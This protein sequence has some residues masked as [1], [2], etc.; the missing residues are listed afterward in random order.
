MKDTL[1]RLI[2][3][4]LVL[5]MVFSMFPAAYAAEN[6][7][8]GDAVT[9][10]S[11]PP[12]AT[13]PTEALASEPTIANEETPPAESGGSSEPTV[14]A[15]DPASTDP[16]AGTT[17][18]DP[19]GDTEA[20][21]P[22]E[23]T[24][25]TE[26]SETT[27]PADPTEDTEPVEPTLESEATEPAEESE[28]TETTEAT[29]PT[30]EPTEATAATQ[31]TD[32][33]ET[34]EP[35]E[36]TE[37]TGPVSDP[38]ADV[39]SAAVWEAT[40]S[41]VTLTGDAVTDLLAIAK[42]QL[43][44]T[45]STRNFVVEGE[46]ED[47]VT[48]GY[49]RYGAWYGLP[50][51][52][53]CAMFV[54][55][56][57]SYAGLTDIPNGAGCQTWINA[58]TE[59]GLYFEADEYLA[60]PGDVIFFDHDGDGRADHVGI[61]SEITED[62]YVTIEGNYSDMVTYVDRTDLDEITGFLQIAGAQ[63]TGNELV[64][65]KI[66]V[67]GGN[68]AISTFASRAV[69]NVSGTRYT[70]A[71]I[72]FN[73][74]S[75]VSFPN[76]YSEQGMYLH[77]VN[78]GDGS[79]HPAYC[80]EPGVN[81]G[82]SYTGGTAQW[83]ALDSSTQKALG[84]TLMY[85]A[86]NSYTSSMSLADKLVY[87][88][89]TQAVIH[90]IMCGYRTLSNLGT[91]TNKSLYNAMISAN[92]PA[93]NMD[94]T[95]DSGYFKS[96]AGT[97]LNKTL[98]AQAYAELE[99][100]I[101]AHNTIP[102][103]TSSDPNDAP[104]YNMT[105]NAAGT[106]YQATIYIGPGLSNGTY[107]FVNGNGLSYEVSGNYLIVSAPKSTTLSGTISC[108]WDGTS[109]VYKNVPSLDEQTFLLWSS[110]KYQELVQ[111]YVNVDAPVPLYFNVRIN[112]TG[113]AT[114]YKTATNGGVEGYAFKFY[115]WKVKDTDGT[116]IRESQTWYAKTGASGLAYPADENYN[117]TDYS[118]GFTFPDA[119]NGTY[120]II[121]V[122]SETPGAVGTAFPDSWT[123]TVYKAD[124]T[125]AN[126]NTY[127]V[128]MNGSYDNDIA[129]CI[130]YE[131][132]GA[133]AR[134]REVPITGLEAGGHVELKVNNYSEPKT[135][136]LSV[137]KAVSQSSLNTSA[138]KANWRIELYDTWAKATVGGTNYL[139]YAYTNSSGNVTFE[140]LEAEK[141][142]YL[143]EAP[144]NRQDKRSDVSGWQ[145]ST[146]VLTQNVTA[147][148]VTSAGTITN[149]ALGSLSVTKTVNP[150]T[151]DKS[152]WAIELYT[153]QADAANGTNVQQTQYTNA[154]G[155]ATFEGLTAGTAY[156]LR[157]A[158]ADRQDKRADVSGWQLSTTVLT[159]SV[160][161]G[162][163]TSAGTIT[164]T[165]M[166][167]VKLHKTANCSSEVYSQI[168]D[169]AM[170]SLAGA[171]YDLYTYNASGVAVKQ[172]TLVTDENGDAASS[173]TYEYGTSGYLV[174]TE[175][176]AGYQLDK[177]KK[178]TF[179][180]DSAADVIVSVSDV[181]IFDPG[182]VPM[183]KID[184]ETGTPQGNTTF[185]G[186][187]FRWDYYDNANWDGTPTRTWYFKTNAKGY[188]AY[189]LDFLLDTTEYPSDELYVD[190]NGK[191]ALP[192]GTMQLTEVKAPTG[193]IVDNAPL[194]ATITQND[195]D[196]KFAWTTGS[197]TRLEVQPDGFFGF[198]N[199]S[200]APGALSIVKLDAETGL[201]AHFGTSFAGCE[202]TVYNNSTNSVKVGDYP[203]AAPGEACYVLTVDAQGNASTEEIFPIGS[204][205]VKETK[206][207]DYY[208]CNTEWSKTVEITGSE[209]APVSIECSNTVVKGSFLLYKIEEGTNSNA[210]NDA[211]PA[212][213]AVALE[214]AQY[215]FWN[216]DGSELGV[217]ATDKNGVIEIKDL[218]YGTYK[219]QEIAA[220]D[221]YELD[222][223]VYE[224]EVTE[225]GKTYTYTRENS[226]CAGSIEVIKRSA[227]GTVLKGVTFLLE[228]TTY[229]KEN[230]TWANWQPVVYR[231]ADSA[232]SFGGCTTKGIVNGE[233]QTD[234]DGRILFEG[235]R[236][237]SQS[238]KIKYRLTE[239][240]TLPGYTLL[241]AP[242]FE[243]ELPHEIDGESVKDISFKVINNE[244]FGFPRTGANGM[245]IIPFGSI[246]AAVSIVLLMATAAPSV[247][248][249]D[250]A[251]NKKSYT[252]KEKK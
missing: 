230:D 45:E 1:K 220:P 128:N 239:T 198:S 110:S 120:D 39:E 87:Q 56:C 197:S 225:Q 55:F 11:D 104:T 196:A 218:P 180:I 21:D 232:I 80:I 79:Y 88:A 223:T 18:T 10:A 114:L 126:S 174:E 242:V 4:M 154:S 175:A 2:S 86:P 139:A 211:P 61:V 98:F 103:T 48:Y 206:G 41:G 247:F 116:V 140:D 84:I 34:T 162:V 192:L 38:T 57:L 165:Q 187:V 85:G 144:A 50:Y 158:P 29:D 54:S 33:T 160:T 234:D 155:V 176:P 73:S 31:P 53:W 94:I 81:P 243:G 90:E 58:L 119:S 130:W 172:E 72:W 95:V 46:G 109:G 25:P 227:D 156:Y 91:S 157:E 171:K 235:L 209:T 106:R 148:V 193:Y 166:V 221:G 204:Y 203:E 47:A 246:I 185:E 214:G 14:P 28:P 245:S 67:P 219:Y 134:L 3:L 26:P 129:G 20:T 183:Q 108:A 63:V 30:G 69:S 163:V 210:A 159:Q 216:P 78:L 117:I 102:S 145:L 189:H 131:N 205:I 164:N 250:K 112:T 228:Y 5:V 252:R 96:L 238:G 136:S 251:V 237:T 71:V 167:H 191:Y 100:K 6:A 236:I 27:A 16:A 51:G 178:Y 217:Y 244:I 152:G 9:T 212:D 240:A 199:D 42:S 123:V 202:F 36:G 32:E 173:K 170:Y 24:N 83:D 52:D 49:T 215:K 40:M 124:G 118:S 115:R 147:G 15:T 111:H 248:T 177:E 101:G 231:E 137:T 74:P 92:Y 13:D 7:E 213:G 168:E 127:Y 12:A 99:A 151:A 37:P 107:K 179:S 222:S 64:Y 122:L 59:A 22:S 75:T 224:F 142:Y 68:T 153:T 241:T 43:G 76:G 233:L 135:G 200:I 207:N 143:R 184:P 208:V 195:N 65:G 181:P 132:G 70:S 201:T 23:V 194:Y 8:P 17:E 133:V 93:G 35:S 141:T 150:S 182:N 249:G 138:N 105:L 190:G 169:N 226:P 161:A 82:S 149:T 44:Y 97:T 60:A 113:A 89:A 19:T 146:T 229:D 77:A 125:V 188:H 121:E 186:A 62:G 66:V